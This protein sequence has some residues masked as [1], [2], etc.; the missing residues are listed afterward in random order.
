ML[1]AG[2]FNGESDN[3]RAPVNNIDSNFL[4]AARLEIAPLG[5]PPNEEGDLRD[6]AARRHLALVLGGAMTYETRAPESDNYRQQNMAGD[7][8]VK[9]HGVSLFGE[10]FRYDRDYNDDV[11]NADK[12]GVGVTTQ[13]GVFIPAPYL[14]EHLEL[15]ARY[16][17]WDP[18]TARDADRAPELVPTTGGSGPANTSSTQGRTS[19][20]AGANWYFF[21]HDLKLQFF[22]THR[23]ETEGYARSLSTAPGVGSVTDQ[24]HDDSFIAQL[25]MRL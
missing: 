7:L 9:W 14:R 4:G 22:Y 17:I 16:Q 25:S 23:H 5:L 3:E 6:A 12:H 24:V 13:L 10:F 20:D 15:V 21:G 18:D 11:A 19:L 1:S 2:L 8:T